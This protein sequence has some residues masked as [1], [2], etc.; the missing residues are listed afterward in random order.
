MYSPPS[1]NM[2]EGIIFDTTTDFC[3]SY[4]I[5][6]QETE[7]DLLLTSG[8]YPKQQDSMIP[9]YDTMYCFAPTTTSSPISN[10][11]HH[12][13]PIDCHYDYFDPINTTTYQGYQWT[14]NNDF[15]QSPPPATTT[16]TKTKKT[17]TKKTTKNPDDRP[18]QCP[19][20]HRAF[21]RKHDLQRHIRVHTGDKPYGCPCCKKAFARTDALKRHLRME[22]ECRESHQVQSMKGTGRRKFRDL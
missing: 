2:N 16:T 22:E 18:F 15:Y 13:S 14:D 17:T 6:K 11:S 3:L 21:A 7:E 1:F 9:F 8:F 5:L 12:S 20:C 10:Y 4:P 19:M